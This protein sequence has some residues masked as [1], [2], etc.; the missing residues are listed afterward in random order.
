MALI[1]ICL[2]V[3]ATILLAAYAIAQKAGMEIT[4]GSLF[5]WFRLSIPARGG[6]PTREPV[7]PGR[8]PDR[9]EHGEAPDIG[10]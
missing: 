9:V 2:V 1:L 7:P 10:R 8:L 6:E 4:V 3:L 5:F